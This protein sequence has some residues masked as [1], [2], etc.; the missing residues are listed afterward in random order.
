MALSP[1]PFY[2]ELTAVQDVGYRIEAKNPHLPRLRNLFQKQGK[3]LDVI[4]L[5]HAASRR[6]VTKE[7]HGLAQNVASGF[8][9]RKTELKQ[10][11]PA[12]R[13]YSHNSVRPSVMIAHRQARAY[14]PVALASRQQ[15]SRQTAS[16]WQHF[17]LAP[18]CA[19][20]RHQTT[21]SILLCRSERA[22]RR[23]RVQVR[24]RR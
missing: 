5:V 7:R 3:N 17:R 1:L 2:F 6:R 20:K 10:Q 4:L 13:R 19:R 18:T 16:C 23:V 24:V 15:L 14:T 9:Q 22:S 8:G 12:T 11:P 21:Q